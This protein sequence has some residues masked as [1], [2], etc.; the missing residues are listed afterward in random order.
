MAKK[1][2]RKNKAKAPRHDIEVT[3]LRDEVEE[4][5]SFLAIEKTDAIGLAVVLNSVNK[6][7]ETALPEMLNMIRR[8][9]DNTDGV[10]AQWRPVALPTRAEQEEHQSFREGTRALERHGLPAETLG[11]MAE[12]DA[13]ASW[14]TSEGD[15]GEPQ[16]EPE[17]RKF[18]APDGRL[19]P[20]GDAPK[21][22]EHAAGSSRR[23][24]NELM[25]DD[26]LEIDIDQLTDMFE[27]LISLAA[28]RPTAPSA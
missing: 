18:R 3:F 17:V 4:V 7:S 8:Y 19:H 25:A 12:G 14:P 16:G 2:G 6:N 1:F 23:R 22:L 15:L 24:W 28:N 5:H 20:M 13:A 10:P 9:L 11:L 27:W 21:F 26:E